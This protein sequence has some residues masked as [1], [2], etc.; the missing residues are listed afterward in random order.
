MTRNPQS[1]HEHAPNQEPKSENGLQFEEVVIFYNF[2]FDL[3]DFI[4][5]TTAARK[6]LET[7][8]ALSAANYLTADIE[9]AERFKELNLW[10]S[11]GVVLSEIYQHLKTEGICSASKW[12]LQHP[13]SAFRLGWTITK[14]RRRM[15]EDAQEGEEKESREG[16]FEELISSTLNFIDESMISIQSLEKLHHHVD[17]L[18]FRPQYLRDVP[19]TRIGLQ[20]FFAT[21][22][23]EQVDVDVWVLVHR[24]GVAILTFGVVFNGQKSVDELVSLQLSNFPIKDLELVRA[25]VEANENDLGKPSKQ[26]YSSGVDWFTYQDLDGVTLVD[27]FGLYQTFIIPAVLGKT[28]SKPTEP[29]NPFWHAYPIVFIKK[30]TP[31]IFNVAAFKQDYPKELAGL[32]LRFPHWRSL[33]DEKIKKVII[34]DLSIVE[35]HSLYV[36]SSHTTVLYYEPYRKSLIDIYRENIPGQE[37]IYRYFL[38]SSVIDVLLIQ[39]GVLSILSNQLRN[40]P[41]NTK[42]LNALKRGAFLALEEFNNI[43]LLHGSAHDIVKQ[44]IVKMGID[45]EYQNLLKKLSNIERLIEVNET[46]RRADRDLLL[47]FGAIIATIMF[48]LGGAWQVVE[49]VKSW[50]DLIPNLNE[51]LKRTIIEAIVNLAQTHPIETT[52]WIYFISVFIIISLLIWSVLPSH[53]DKP[54]IDVDQSQPAYDTGFSWPHSHVRI[55]G[56]EPKIKE[57]NS[58]EQGT[59]KRE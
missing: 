40:L 16:T 21:L 31:D 56:I 22:G 48:G 35:D 8:I 30:I 47:K 45:E 42:K 11:H 59:T 17:R 9:V 39:R 52:L 34:D 37:W 38:T 18:L 51:G 1:Q 12:I 57:D 24:S 53:N 19:F 26:R 20:P 4:N 50:N 23:G 55:T 44:S 2:V 5:P 25:I 15:Q 7:D 54:I 32:I 33:K 13:R 46:K 58:S 10:R 14:S 3:G 28:P 36:E 6:L 49:T 29:R 41:A 43:I 27:V